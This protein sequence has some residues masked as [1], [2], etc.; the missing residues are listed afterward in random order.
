MLT[1][2]ETRPTVPSQRRAE[3]A[4]SSPALACAVC[5]GAATREAG[6]RDIVLY[7]CR[8]CGHC[9]TDV[10]ALD[11]LAEYDEAWESLHPNWFENPN[12]ALFEMVATTIER[13][14][15]DAAVI[16]V[17]AGRGELLDYLR[18]RDTRLRLTGLDISLHPEIDGVEFVSGDFVQIDFGARRW[19]IVV[20][21]ATIEHV[22][23]V[24]MF[25]RRLHDLLEPGGL[26]IVMTVDDQS[27]LYAVARLLNRVGYRTAFE[28]LYDRFHLNHF[29]SGS[30]RT[31]LENEGFETV[32]HHHHNIPIRSVD[33]PNESTLSR[34][35]V[36]GT[37]VL[38]R[39]T[40]RTYEQTIVSRARWINP[41]LRPRG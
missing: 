13:H 12:T 35:G 2:R 29:T 19:D 25:A 22:A 31:L 10:A 18:R 40:G 1:H 36:W 8:R 17:G 15:P 24:R 39:L 11:H 23:D 6:F 28:R 41:A 27:I 32:A 7:R 21:L 30:L 37:F 26:A 4:G 34:A 33:M 38:G 5:E 16:D 14:K 20:S 3:R 9:F